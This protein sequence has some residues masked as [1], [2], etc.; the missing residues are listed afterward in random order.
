VEKVICKVEYTEELLKEFNRLHNKYTSRILD[1]FVN[2]MAVIMFVCDLVIL[3][4][5]GFSGLDI[6]LVLANII[7]VIVLIST[8]TNIVSDMATGWLLKSDKVNLNSKA[9]QTFTKDAVSSVDA[10]T[11]ST[12]PYSKLYKVMETDKY[13]F[14]YLNRVQAGIVVKANNSDEEI[15]FV[16]EAL[17]EN[18]KKYIIYKK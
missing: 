12:I 5:E 7:V 9:E 6:S 10:M 15:E 2:V 14:Y 11:T 3:F 17:K 16:R 8:N 18:V 13:I 4:L 1:K